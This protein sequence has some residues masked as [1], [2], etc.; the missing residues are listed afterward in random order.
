MLHEIASNQKSRILSDI[1]YTPPGK[2]DTKF[3][4]SRQELFAR[5]N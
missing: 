2:R 3:G 5:A 1:N 4:G